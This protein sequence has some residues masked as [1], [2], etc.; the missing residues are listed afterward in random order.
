MVGIY[1]VGLATGYSL[2]PPRGSFKQLRK[3]LHTIYDTQPAAL[4]SENKRECSL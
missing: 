2:I 1:K 4:I 3:Y